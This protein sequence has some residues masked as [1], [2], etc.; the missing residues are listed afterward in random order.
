M[1]L[2]DHG[3]EYGKPIFI[4]IFKASKELELWIWDGAIFRLFKTYEICSFSGELG[5]KT[6]Q[7]DR[8]APEGFYFVGPNNLNPWSSYHLS[9]DLGYPNAFERAHGYTGSALMV[10]GKCVS[11]GCYAMTDAYINEIYALAQSAFENGQSFFRVHAFPFR[12][13][14]STLRK[15]NFHQWYS[16][17]QNLKPGY[18]YFNEERIPPNVVVRGGIYRFEKGIAPYS[19]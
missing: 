15:Y 13:E 12:M 10:H 11:I 8:Q 16:F 4:R 5:P 2:R 17:W 7:G 19:N 9:F 3:L 18:D 14:D 1:E 6:R